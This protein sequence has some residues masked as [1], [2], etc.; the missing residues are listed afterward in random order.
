MLGTIDYK[1]G[2]KKMLV[3]TDPERRGR[4]ASALESCEAVGTYT[5]HGPD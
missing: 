1:C 3:H 2:E 5:E 4:E